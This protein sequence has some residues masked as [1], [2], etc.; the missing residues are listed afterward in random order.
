[1]SNKQLDKYGFVA[2]SDYRKKI[3]ERLKEAPATP[4]RISKETGIHI[5]HVSTTLG[6]LR[7]EGIVYCVNPQRKKGRVYRLTELG[8]WVAGRIGKT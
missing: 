2:A 7:E 4:R 8:E 5:S 1:M 6:E 3:V